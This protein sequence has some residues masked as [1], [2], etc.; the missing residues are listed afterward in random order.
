MGLK[1]ADYVVKGQSVSLD[2]KGSLEG[3]EMFLSTPAI[4]TGHHPESTIGPSTAYPVPSWEASPTLAS[5]LRLWGKGGCSPRKSVYNYLL[6]QGYSFRGVLNEKYPCGPDRAVKKM[7]V[8]GILQGLEGWEELE[9]RGMGAVGT[10]GWDEAGVPR[11]AG[12][13]ARL[14]GTRHVCVSGHGRP[15]WEGRLKGL[16]WLGTGDS[17]GF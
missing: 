7:F 3:G 13:E 9:G 16:M 4:S 6:N 17:E 15:T 14:L 10:G 8:E 5:G 1:W 12:T 11:G 2:L